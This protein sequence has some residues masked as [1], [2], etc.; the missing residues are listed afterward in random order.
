MQHSFDKESPNDEAETTDRAGR[1]AMSFGADTY[2]LLLIMLLVFCVQREGAGKEASFIVRLLLVG[3][4][5]FV[6][7]RKRRQIAHPDAVSP[8]NVRLALAGLCTAVLLSYAGSPVLRA[9]I[10]DDPSMVGF[11]QLRQA[12]SVGLLGFWML[13]I[14]LSGIALGQWIATRP[15]GVISLCRALAVASSCVALLTIVEWLR[16]TGGVLGRY[17]FLPPFG[18]AQGT[19]ALAGS[20]ALVFAPAGF[21]WRKRSTAYRAAVAALMMA[22]FVSSL[23]ILSREEQ[24]SDLLR[25]AVA[26]AL[27]SSLSRRARFAVFVLTGI[28]VAIVIVVIV[29]LELVALFSDA[30]N[31]KSIDWFIRFDLLRS[32]VNLFQAHPISGVGYGLF[33]YMSAMTIIVL[34]NN[35]LVYSPH[36]A[37]AAF[38]SEGGTVML[39][40]VIAFFIVL[41]RTIRRLWDKLI[42]ESIL[43]EVR[44][45]YAAVTATIVVVALRHFI[46]NSQLL[47]PPGEYGLVQIAFVNWTLIGVI[48]SFE[49]TFEI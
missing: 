34:N 26:I 7:L 19:A 30:V 20:L 14:A 2:V 41:F 24:L 18:I 8:R 3:I 44:P 25:I 21:G 49:V 31:P 33:S 4:G 48:S 37:I 10:A 35:S 1:L 6:W 46:S 17:N 23:V 29:R 32:S 39:L 40:A 47:P 36:N 27:A 28:V 12:P 11:S 43:S 38:A 22:S 9:W 15:G 13:G 5:P 45:A 16:Q 42:T